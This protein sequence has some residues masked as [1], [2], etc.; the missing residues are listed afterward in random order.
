MRKAILVLMIFVCGWGTAE[1]RK[2]LDVDVAE[3]TRV[4]NQTL[5]LNGAGVR[6][7]TVLHVK[8]YVAAFYA[9]TQLNTEDEVLASPGPLYLQLTYVRSFDKARVQKAWVWQFEQSGTYTYDG[10]ERDKKILVDSFGEIKKGG[11]ESIALVG[12]E[13]RIYDDGVLK[14]T[15]KGRDFQKAFLSMWFGKKPVMTELKA[16]LLGGNRKE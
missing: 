2:I 14:S 4:D 5:K 10:F 7:A 1:A 12:D 8:I 6:S 16:N 3:E 11:V 15:I 9:P 13:T